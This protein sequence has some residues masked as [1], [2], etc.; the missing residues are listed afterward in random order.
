MPFKALFGSVCLAL[1]LSPLAA[2]P[3]GPAPQLVNVKAVEAGAPLPDRPELVGKTETGQ[4]IDL[5]ALR[6]QVVMVLVWSTNCPV[7][8]NKMPELRANL[9]GW[10][11]QSFQIISINTD[12][13][14]EP[15]QQWEA[16]RRITVQAS[17]Q[18]PSIWAHSAGFKTNLP[19]G[20]STAGEPVTA[21]HLPTL[22][23]ID[24][25]GKLR[26]HAMGRMP[27]DVWDTIADLL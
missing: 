19:L 13:Q 1:M 18:W 17:Q 11:G 22:Y 12:Q 25:Q 3:T 10:A 6:G 8:L 21:S 20:N 27:A 9:A 14:R 23:V 24:R 2:A 26:L 7:C 16:A 4:A 5:S 15:L